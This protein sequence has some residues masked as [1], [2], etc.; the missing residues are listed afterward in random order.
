[1]AALEVTPQSV[2]G[3]TGSSATGFSPS[4]VVYAMTNTGAEPEAWSAST[5]SGWLSLAPSTGTLQPNGTVQVKVTTNF[6]TSLLPT[7]IH[8]GTVTFSNGQTRTV[9]LTSTGVVSTVFADGFERGT[10]GP[11]WAVSGVGPVNTRPIGTYSEPFLT[12]AGVRSLNLSANTRGIAT[13]NEATLSLNLSGQSNLVLSFWARNRGDAPHGPPATPFVNGADF[14]G[15]ALST[16]GVSWFE[17]QSLRSVPSTWTE[18]TVDLDAA[19]A[20]HGLSYGANVRI[21]FN[22]YGTH[23]GLEFDDLRVA[24]ITPQRLRLILPSVVD[25]GSSTVGTV[26]VSP[27]QSTPL[28]VGLST[29]DASGSVPATVTIP[30]GEASTTFAIDTVSDA[31]LGGSR[32]L[33][34]QANALSF[35]P[36]AETMEIRDSQTATLSLN[37]PGTAIEG[38]T[39]LSIFAAGSAGLQHTAT[40]LSGTVSVSAPVASAVRVALAASSDDLWLPSSVE[41]PAGATAATFEIEVAEDYELEGPESV[42]VTAHVPNWVD[43]VATMA[44]T[45]RSTTPLAIAI[46]SHVTEGTSE[47]TGYVMR[48]GNSESGFVVTLTSSDPAR[49]TVPASVTI[50]TGSWGAYFL[51]TTPD[52]S[53]VSGSHTVTFTASAAGFADATT[54]SDIVDNEV[55]HFSISSVAAAQIRNAPIAVTIEARNLSDELIDTFTGVVALSSAALP[56]SPAQVTLTRGKWTGIIA[57]GADSASATLFAQN[58]TGVNGTSNSF[59]VALGPLDHLAISGVGTQQTADTPFALTVSAVDAGGNIIPSYAGP[60]T[61]GGLARDVREPVGAAEN[62]PSG[63][64]TPGDL[65]SRHASARVQTVYHPAEV[66]GAGE[67]GS[68][69]IKFTRAPSVPYYDFTVRVQHTAPKP[70]N[71]YYSPY[72]SQQFVNLGWSEVFRGT[73]TVSQTGWVEFPFSTPFAY[74]GVSDLLVDFSFFNRSNPTGYSGSFEVTAVS[75][76]RSVV[77]SS[78]S[79]SLDPTSQGYYYSGDALAY[80]PNVRFSSPLRTAPIRPT[81]PVTLANGTWSG[82]VSVPYVAT[83]A[84]ILASAGPLSGQ[85]GKFTVV[86]TLPPPGAGVIAREDWESDVSAAWVFSGG[87][88]N[89]YIQNLQVSTTDTPHG[90]QRQLAFDRNVQYGGVVRNEATWSNDLTGQRG[91]TLKF[92][93]RGFSEVSDGPPSSPVSSGGGFDGVSISANGTTWYEV[94]GLR[95]LP[96]SWTQY[97][98]DLDAAIRTR[99]LSY[100]PGFRIR[101]NQYRQYTTSGGITIDDI[102]LTS[103]PVAGAVI[104]TLPAQISEG[105]PTQTGTVSIPFA[106][107]Y[108][109]AVTLECSAGAKVFVPPLV[110]VPSGQTSVSFSFQI[111]DDSLADGSKMVS[112]KATA[113]NFNGSGAMMLLMDNDLPAF[114]LNVP[115]NSISENGAPFAATLTIPSQANAPLTFSVTSSDSTAISTPSSVTIP[116]GATSVGVM[117]S[118]VNDSKVDGAQIATVTAAIVGLPPQTATITVLDDESLAL[119][120]E[121]TL[122]PATTAVIEG[123]GTTLTSYRAYLPGT[124]TSATTVTFTASSSRVTAP[125]TS[126]IAAGGTVGSVV[127]FAVPENLVSD[128]D[129]VVTL[130]ASA[131]GFVTA[132]KTLTVMDNDVDHF[133]ISPIGGSQVRGAPIPIVITAKA[134]NGTTP[135][136][137]SGSVS[138]SGSAA[139][140]PSPVT[141]TGGIWSGNIRSDIIA[142][143]VTFSVGD[144]NGHT[145]AS[146]AFDVTTGPF[147]GYQWSVIGSQQPPGA[148]IPITVRATDAGGNFSPEIN[149]PVTVRA[150]HWKGTTEIGEGGFS[151]GDILATSAKQAR[152]QT[153]F[154]AVDLGSP[155]TLGGLILFAKSGANGQSLSNFTVRLKPTSRTAFQSGDVWENDDWTVVYQSTL[156]ISANGSVPIKFDTPFD[157]DGLTNLIIE[158]SFSN[159]ATGN[160]IIW[161]S[162][163][164]YSTR[165]YPTLAGYSNTGA[166]NPLLWT[167]L[168]TSASGNVYRMHTKLQFLQ[169]TN[170]T[171]ST[172]MNLSSGVWN[173]SAA[174]TQPAEQMFMEIID[175]AGRRALSNPFSIAV[176]IGGADLAAPVQF[177]LPASISEN[178]PGA[179]ASV[180]ISSA[181]ASDRVIALTSDSPLS[182]GVQAQVTIPA[183]Q[184][185]A[186]FG[187][188]PTNNSAVTG[189]LKV[190]VTATIGGIYSG[191]GVTQLLDDDTGSVAVSLPA[192][193]REYFDSTI[194][195][196]VTISP[197]PDTIQTITLSSSL[198]GTLSV[199][200]QLICQPGQTSV[201]FTASSINDSI[202][203]GNRDV[204]ITASL[205]GWL[206]GSATIGIIDDDRISLSVGSAYIVKE[207]GIAGGSVY[208]SGTL[209]T[210]LT[211]SLTSSDPLHLT[212]PATVT[213]PAGANSIS[214]TVTAPENGAFEGRRNVTLTASA[215]GV[216]SA[217]GSAD[218]YDNDLHHFSLNPDTSQ[219]VRGV[220]FNAFVTP[221]AVDGSAISGYAGTVSLSTLG[222]I[223]SPTFSPATLSSFAYGTEYASV[224][225]NAAA[226]NVQLV[227]TSGSVSSSSEPFNVGYGPV[228]HYTWSNIA[229][230][231]IAGRPF[232]ATLTAADFQGN[233]IPTQTGYVLLS[234]PSQQRAIGPPSG[235]SSAFPLATNVHD[236]RTQVVY[237]ASELGTAALLYSLSLN[238]VTPP[239]Q[240]LNAWTLRMKSG[241]VV[242]SWNSTGWTTVFS[243]NHSITQSGWNTFNFTT[244][245]SYNGTG[246]L[247][248][249][250]SF[251]NASASTAG[252]IRTFLSSTRTTYG[253]QNSV[254][255]SAGDPLL[256][257]SSPVSIGAFPTTSSSVPQII[258]NFGAPP[259]GVPSAK[260]IFL[261]NGSWT[262]SISLP[263]P[264]TSGPLTATDFNGVTG[265]SN[266]FVI[267]TAVD[268]DA[269]KLPDWWESANGLPPGSGNA[270]ADGEFDGLNNLLEY[271]LNS[272]PRGNST[273]L[274]PSAAVQTNPADGLKYLTF[275]YRRRIG[276]SGVA[277]TVQTSVDCITWTSNPANYLQIGAIPLDD[278]VTEQVVVRVLPAIAPGIAG[279]FVRLRVSAP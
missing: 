42:S 205:S 1:M 147:V 35:V 40:V 45:D 66:K 166:R 142:D 238:V 97:S 226:T 251:N 198:S 123:T 276:I 88:S 138:I 25:E 127:T 14:D 133:D 273:G 219:K 217:L 233:P 241:A 72:S 242:G 98:V 112:I 245:F 212:V 171:I 119:R 264:M 36:T 38:T 236:E 263:P 59:S 180:T 188:L 250:F 37:I 79:T 191:R 145:G 267:S 117:L 17:V 102:E 29:D 235:T 93:A 199:P 21:R 275:N 152:S 125:S 71:S 57:V 2:E 41:I 68:M 232:T 135:T 193:A 56:V 146:N 186:T 161:E 279:R 24:K 69:A 172:P 106:V 178:G 118:P 203:N 50:P 6:T 200:T 131:P 165:A 262:G 260:A 210:P 158:F 83:Q 144:G 28:S 94:Q 258:F 187:L 77:D 137:Y 96:N 149:Q 61:L 173:G 274:L 3:F 87:I 15:V 63:Y 13:R 141:V 265:T 270:T 209:S 143:G 34:V 76:Y 109:L 237:L 91:L 129:E 159:T 64:P 70:S 223:G 197:A 140:S 100:G 179:S 84:Q 80:L 150:L 31:V 124:V 208:T 175:A 18:F 73:V 48:T 139:V 214:F 195:G 101:F 62:Y 136:G 174:F 261:Q 222:G 92:W 43:G 153:I 211:V 116:V 266:T 103:S 4:A 249:D 277:F 278:G 65:D 27:V 176:P 134:A 177:A 220:A 154:P 185:T 189:P 49:A 240:T 170:A 33:S 85:S 243:G 206:P 252:S 255:G 20:A 213:V 184:T 132:T 160:T 162:D 74:D 78:H 113:P 225:I 130:S 10:L 253:V 23:G 221:C 244:P 230:P 120:L 269:N 248:V 168:D 39:V 196:W 157:Y 259:L 95:S 202:V 22:Q 257:S 228:H 167:A 53:F 5:A 194:V 164:A 190:S 183:G 104:V 115:T 107:G 114:T 67:L 155:K 201:P 90:G 89:S 52:D 86:A 169:P 239:G 55:H 163:Y 30:A 216:A 54:T 231:Q 268:A 19:L 99:G 271:A 60:V 121:S 224:T 82:A 58:S 75:D 207:G 12:H 218:V 229:S 181:S 46:S 51:V 110:T 151:S 11:V 156:S 128:G 204:T 182:L 9:R 256:W 254:S 47:Y 234:G 247:L 32:T 227:A 26:F 16:D 122:T 44:I 8:T 192:T 215:P 105:G 108:D 7:G 272:D 246:D 111:L 148:A 126:T 81:T